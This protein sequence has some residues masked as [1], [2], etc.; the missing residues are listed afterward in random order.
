MKRFIIVTIALIYSITGA[1]MLFAGGTTPDAF[2]FTDRTNVA[3]STEYKSNAITVTGID[4]AAPIS[5]AGGTYSINGGTYT[6]ASG[7]VSLGNTVKVRKMS[8]AA[9]ATTKSATLTIGGVSDTFSVTTHAATQ[10]DPFTFTNQTNAAL[11]TEFKS[12]AITVSG[13]GAAASISI[14]GG[15]YSVNGGAYTSDGSTVVNGNTVKV[16]KMSATA[17]ATTKSAT[18]TI[19][20]ASDTFSVTTQT[21]SPVIRTQ[22]LSQTVMAGQTAT[23]RVVATG[24]ATLHYQWKKGIANVGTDSAS[25]A[26]ANAQTTD[27]GSYTVTVSNSAGSETSNPATLTVNS[28]FGLKGWQLNET[29]TGI[30]ASGLTEADLTVFDLNGADKGK[31]EWIVAEGYYLY[32]Y[33]NQVIENKIITFTGYMGANLG[34]TVLR[35]CIIRPTGAQ[36]GMAI[37]GMTGGTIENCII[38]GSK[39]GIKNVA[40]TGISSRNSIIRGNLIHDVDNGFFSFN[41]AG[42]TIIEGNYVY[43][44]LFQTGS[45]DH[46]AGCSIWE[47]TGDGIDILNNRIVMNDPVGALHTSGAFFSQSRVGNITNVRVEGNLLVSAAYVTRITGDAGTTYLPYSFINNRL[48]NITEYGTGYGYYAG[49]TGLVITPTWTDNYVYDPKAVDAKGSLITIN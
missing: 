45:D 18:L 39:L 23:F 43:N 41:S 22:P 21:T 11:S 19:G 12:N 40:H 47:A 5:V 34:G 28:G 20:G 48:Q 15:T 10:P 4:T 38:D 33:G 32:L 2:T 42:K 44:I 25:F 7:T 1:N 27:A 37:V 3:L 14:I 29:N 26:I 17:Y 46:L 8:A 24:A 6:S 31:G 13:L 36:D 16:R 35:N 9:Y 49:N 30:A